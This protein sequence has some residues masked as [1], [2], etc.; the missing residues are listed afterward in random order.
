MPFSIHARGRSRAGLLGSVLLLLAGCA[1]PPAK[2]PAVPGPEHWQAL[3]R[4]D[5][6][7]IHQLILDAHPGSRDELNPEF[8]EWTETGYREALALLPRVFHYDSMLAAVRYYTTGFRDNHLVYSDN[9]RADDALI[10]QAGWTVEY[11]DNRYIVTGTATAEAWPV[12]L[13]PGGSILLQCDGRAVD[14]ILRDDVAPFVDRRE[15]PRTPTRLA[16]RLSVLSLR[17]S[18]LKRCQFSAADGATFDLDVVYQGITI[19]QYWDWFAAKSEKPMPDRSNDFQLQDGILWIRASNFSLN[20]EQVIALETM[21]DALPK[22]AGVRAI[23]FDARLNGGGDSSVGARIFEAAT[24]GLSYDTTGLEQLPQTYAQ[25][26]VSDVAI[27]EAEERVAQRRAQY[28]ADSEQLRDAEDHLK[29]LQDARQKG[30]IW[31]KQVEGPRL[32]RAEIGRRGGHL[33]RFDGPIALLTRNNCASSC[34]DFA[35]LVLSVPGAIHLGQETSSD[36]LYIDVAHGNLPSG[37]GF[38]IPLKVWRNRL[39]GNNET[40]KPDVPLDFDAMDEATVRARVI[41]ALHLPV[42]PN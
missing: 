3:A 32:D 15:L 40:L 35:D 12:A 2:A 1:T 23:V 21:L 5:L 27:G 6:D 25:W 14:S 24:G 16:Y 29:A 8:M 9:I 34:L 17:G 31:V 7:A 42:E 4:A 18:E 39:R 13:P 30:E 28:G 20:P 33:K 36:T 41:D 19:D 10:H 11:T 26:R 37:N 22:L 38:V